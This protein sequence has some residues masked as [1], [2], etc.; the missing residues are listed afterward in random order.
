MVRRA[1]HG[2]RRRPNEGGNG[3]NN[4]D[5][6]NVPP[7]SACR[8]DILIRIVPGLPESCLLDRFGRADQLARWF[9]DGLVQA[10]TDADNGI[11]ARIRGYVIH[12]P[13]PRN[14][15]DD[16]VRLSDREEHLAKWIGRWITKPRWDNDHDPEEALMEAPSEIDESTIRQGNRRGHGGAERTFGRTRVDDGIRH[17]YG[18]D[19]SSLGLEIIPRA[20]DQELQY[21]CSGIVSRGARF[22]DDLEFFSYQARDSR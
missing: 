10:V 21:Q 12:S 20:I 4:C 2:L 16:R 18:P 8:P 11:A 5:G 7:R 22:A 19:T 13:F 3:D 6:H 9:A 1:Q 15:N 17:S 14:Q